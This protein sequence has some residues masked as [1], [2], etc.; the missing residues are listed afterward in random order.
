MLARL[1][2]PIYHALQALEQQ[3]TQ[4]ALLFIRLL[5]SHLEVVDRLQCLMIVLLDGQSV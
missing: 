5:L 1:H 4:L 3:G 2:Q